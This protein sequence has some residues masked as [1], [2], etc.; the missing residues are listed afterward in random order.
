MKKVVL[1]LGF[2][3]C[4]MFSSFAQGNNEKPISQNPSQ[5]DKKETLNF[6]VSKDASKRL[7][8][9]EDLEKSFIVYHSKLGTN[10]SFPDN[11]ASIII[12][13]AEKSL[14]DPDAR[15]RKTSVIILGRTEDAKYLT[16]LQPLLADPEK[17]VKLAVLEAMQK[18]ADT[19]ST[20]LIVGDPSAPV[21]LNQL[22][23]ILIKVAPFLDDPDEKIRKEAFTTICSI[24][25]KE[26][27]PYLIKGLNSV[28]ADIRIKA[29]EALDR[30]D[31][32]EG[33][34]E[35]IKSLQSKDSEI[36]DKAIELLGGYA[37]AWFGQA[38]I[39][40]EEKI[41]RKTLRLIEFLKE[42]IKAEDP[43]LRKASDEIL[44]HFLGN[45]PTLEEYGGNP[46]FGSFINNPDSDKWFR[47]ATI[48]AEIGWFHKDDLSKDDENF[49]INSLRDQDTKMRQIAAYNLDSTSFLASVEPLTAALN[50]MDEGVRKN[51]AKAL[52]NIAESGRGVFTPEINL[53]IIKA[54]EKISSQ[55]I[56]NKDD[57]YRIRDIKSYLIDVIS[58]TKEKRAVKLL[59]KL[60][61]DPDPMIRL[62]SAETLTEITGESFEKEKNE[63]LREYLKE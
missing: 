46:I 19:L 16:I 8:A 23:S 41:G 25:I 27:I 13:A 12:S 24:R 54:L 57:M 15:I 35:V 63:G 26:S 39:N 62:Q 55:K 51:S 1:I 45:L 6:L 53:D 49:L 10:F 33:I 18:I 9:F 28:D 31:E 60:L 48:S 11:E 47:M 7:Q 30:Q 22:H 2:I 59:K 43:E 56:N 21:P 38:A 4:S 32:V 44:Q 36:R 58:A 17:E 61:K 34:N 42:G 5:A 50:D 14:S 40:N 3:L 52:K 29:L 37:F 20:I